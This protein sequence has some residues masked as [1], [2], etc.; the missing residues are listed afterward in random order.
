VPIGRI[1]RIDHGPSKGEWTWSFMLGHSDFAK[2]NSSKAASKQQAADEVR[3]WFERYLVIP[4]D[5][6]GGL[7][8]EPEEWPPDQASIEMKML[9]K[10]NPE[11]FRQ[12]V[13]NIRAG[14]IPRNPYYWRKGSGNGDG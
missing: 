3:A 12:H 1:I 13:E 6:G 9:R 11:K 7:G 2:G 10:V 4:E 8:V 5:R 14:K